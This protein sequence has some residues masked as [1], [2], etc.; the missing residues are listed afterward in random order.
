MD[1]TETV[2]IF[3]RNGQVAQELAHLQQTSD[4]T[5]QFAGRERCDLMTTDPT[6]LIEAVQPIGVINA[7]AYTAVDRAETEPDAAYR[8]NR[9]AVGEMARACAA[10]DIPFVHISTD[11]VFD[12]KKTEPYVE[13]DPRNPLSVYGASKA[14][15]EDAVESVGGHWTIFRTAWVFSPF[16]ANFIKTMRRFAA[17]R[18]VV[19]VVADQHGR[20]TLAADVAAFC[21]RAAR[22]GITGDASLQGLFHLAGAD[23]AVWAE[24]AEFVFEDAE[25]RTGRRPA[26]E[27]VSTADYPTPAKR[28]ANSRLNTNKLQVATG[29]TPHPWRRTVEICLAGG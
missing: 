6:G 7:S 21:V 29:W 24:L 4:L 1:V 11:Y 10:A 2:L 25:R 18:D 5:L 20:P 14:A 19:R 8:L 3:G 13:T 27:R 26:L 9:D 28:P 17:E 23:D 15:G 12:G 16:G 22:R